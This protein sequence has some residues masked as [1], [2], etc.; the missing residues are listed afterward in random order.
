MWNS[1]SGLYRRFSVLGIF[2]LATI[3]IASSVIFVPTETLAATITKT[4]LWDANT[5]ADLKGYNVY[6]S[7]TDGGPYT[8]K[9]G[10]AKVTSYN[11]TLSATVPTNYFWV[12]TAVDTAG[13][14]SG[15]SNQATFLFEPDLTAPAAP[16]NLRLAP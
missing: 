9:A 15:Y 16:G 12:V 13:N 6:Q 4:L 1:L 2:C 3:L 10:L 7:I 14:E 8:L 11:V 5:E